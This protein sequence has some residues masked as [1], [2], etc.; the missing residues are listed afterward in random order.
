MVWKVFNVL[1]C[2]LIALSPAVLNGQAPDAQDVTQSFFDQHKGADPTNPNRALTDKVRQPEVRIEQAPL[3]PRPP[4]KAVM[5]EKTLKRI[6]DLR[7]E[8]ESFV[9]NWIRA[10][11]KAAELKFTEFSEN[12]TLKEANK[13]WEKKDK[14]RELRTLEAKAKTE[15]R[16]S[17]APLPP[18]SY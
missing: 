5:D 16:I 17:T 10:K 14:A 1:G 4:E 9:S 18:R 6:N 13:A 3:P 7:Q 15:V 8:K 11:K 12:R 2:L